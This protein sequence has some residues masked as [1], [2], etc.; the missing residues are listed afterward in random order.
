[1][2]FYRREYEIIVKFHFNCKTAKLQNS[3]KMA[4]NMIVYAQKIIFN[5]LNLLVNV[6][7]ILQFPKMEKEII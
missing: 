1:M 6:E 7:E 2:I 4:K 3:K 5:I